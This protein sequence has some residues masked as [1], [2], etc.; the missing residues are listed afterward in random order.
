[1]HAALDWLPGL[2]VVGT[3]YRQSHINSL[4]DGLFFT[5]PLDSH[6]LFVASCYFPV[7]IAADPY[8]I[9]ILI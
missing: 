1:M 7:H 5:V 9:W 8:L 6:V 2:V 4:T 3:A